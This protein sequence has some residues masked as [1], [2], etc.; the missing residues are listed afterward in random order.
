MSNTFCHV[1]FGCEVPSEVWDDAVEH[2]QVADPRT[3][4]WHSTYD[5]NRDLRWFGVS[6]GTVGNGFGPIPTVDDATQAEVIGRWDSFSEATRKALGPPKLQMMVG[7][8]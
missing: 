6:G 3:I 5:Q 8:N 1:I 7:I 2:H 4:G